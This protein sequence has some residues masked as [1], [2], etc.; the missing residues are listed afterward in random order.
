[1][2]PLVMT[3][4]GG[5]RYHFGRKASQM[6]HLDTKMQKEM[7]IQKLRE[8]SF[9]ITKQ[10]QMILDVIFSEECSSCKEIYYEIKK[11]DDRIGMATVYRMVS[12]LEEMGAI[13][14]ED[15]YK[16]FCDVDYERENTLIIELDDHTVIGLCARDCFKEILE[17]LKSCGYAD[18]QCIVSITLDTGL[19]M[20]C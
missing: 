15:T 13:Y 10:R 2:M 14:R 18:Q 7:I 3:N 9:R 17:G 4:K 5:M 20:E 12:L 6:I 8:Q 1:M 19:K 16:I 11:E